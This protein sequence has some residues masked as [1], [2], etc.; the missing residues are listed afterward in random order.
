MPMLM[1]VYILPAFTEKII[2]TQ[3]KSP[4]YS[5]INSNRRFAAKPCKALVFPQAEG[6]NAQIQK[7][8]LR[9]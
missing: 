3:I 4:S 7:S 6:E 8:L 1:L 5:P 2:P 9:I